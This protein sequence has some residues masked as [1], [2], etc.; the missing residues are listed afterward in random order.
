VKTFEEEYRAFLAR[1]EVV[2][3][4]KYLWG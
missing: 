3:E 2:S 1:H 4:E